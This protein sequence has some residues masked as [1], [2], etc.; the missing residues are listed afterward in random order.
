MAIGAWDE[1]VCTAV[2][3][4]AGQRGDK[5]ES[6]GMEVTEHSVGLPATHELDDVFVHSGAE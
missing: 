1:G 4:L 2:E 3:H 5:W 6:L